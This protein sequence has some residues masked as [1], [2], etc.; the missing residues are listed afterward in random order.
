MRKNKYL[1]V[2]PLLILLFSCSDESPDSVSFTV[3]NMT[4]LSIEKCKF[5][6][7][8]GGF[9]TLSFSDSIEFSQII[10][11]NDS[12]TCVWKKPKLFKSD[13]VFYLKVN[14]LSTEIGYYSNGIILNFYDKYSIK[15]YGDSIR[16]TVV[17][18]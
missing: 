14:D 3:K 2:L 1:L 5:Y 10:K 8:V 6:G 12:I 9:G 13:G 15:V 18:K 17:K 7:A 16:T 11:P 4:N